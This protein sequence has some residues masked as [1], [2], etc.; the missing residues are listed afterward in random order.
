[1]VALAQLWRHAF[2]EQYEG[3]MKTNSI[4]QFTQTMQSPLGL[5]RIDACANFVRGI[6]FVG[7]RWEHRLGPDLRL[8]SNSIIDQTQLQLAQYFDAARTEFDLPLSPQGTAF[9]ESVWQEIS[10]IAYGDS[11]TYGSIAKQLIKPNASRAVGA[12]TGRNPISIVI[13]C[14]RVMGG[15]QALTG[16]AGG[17]DRKRWLLRHEQSAHE[18]AQHNQAANRL[19]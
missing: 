12:A 8:Q 13:P 1:M 5:I 2:M 15:N 6:W 10:R 3:K 16:Y 18:Q 19:L 4:E 11:N 14:H 17:L 9:Q 7:Q